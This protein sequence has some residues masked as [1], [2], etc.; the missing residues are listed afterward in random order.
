[1]K[2]S[3][4]Q[5]NPDYPHGKYDNLALKGCDCKSCK[6]ARDND[7]DVHEVDMSRVTCVFGGRVL[8]AYDMS[9]E[10]EKENLK[11]I[12]NIYPDTKPH[13]GK[14]HR[15]KKEGRARNESY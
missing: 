5:I 8:G 7:L 1:M 10:L 2:N 13:I 15:R 3:C 12:T 9:K 14:S 6:T 11:L 4:S